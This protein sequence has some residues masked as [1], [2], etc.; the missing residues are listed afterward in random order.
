MGGLS[1]GVLDLRHSLHHRTA[2]ARLG[3]MVPFAQ[4]LERCG[5]SRYWLAEHHDALSAH[6]SPEAFLS[7]LAAST[8]KMVVGSG[9]VLLP[10]YNPLKV[11]TTFTALN[12]LF[13]GRIELGVARGPGAPPSR[14]QRLAPAPDAFLPPAFFAKVRELAEARDESERGGEGSPVPMGMPMPPIWLLGIS[15]EGAREA[16]QLR[17]RY[18]VGMSYAAPRLARGLVASTV[19]AYR[20][21]G[22]TRACIA[23]SVIAHAN[24]SRARELADRWASGGGVPVNVVGTPASCASALREIAEVHG[25]P[26]LLIPTPA[27]MT[28]EGQQAMF[29]ELARELALGA[30]APVLASGH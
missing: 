9:G 23:V 8:E 28:F 29:T 21:A 11:A 18:C 5:Y 17:L 7:M 20:E 19:E 3:G 26:E 6:G 2:E 22:G 24:E 25:V 15:P 12:A 13:P 10:Y 16:A 30:Q 14:A 27:V 4:H 1:V